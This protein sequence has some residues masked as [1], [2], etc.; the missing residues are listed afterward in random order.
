MSLSIYGRVNI[1][2]LVVLMIV[3]CG[4]KNLYSLTSLPLT[5]TLTTS[6][7]RWWNKKLPNFSQNCPKSSHTFYIIVTS[8]EIAQKVTKLF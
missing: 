1:L 3:V 6:V 7:I 4:R 5:F 2:V 8:L